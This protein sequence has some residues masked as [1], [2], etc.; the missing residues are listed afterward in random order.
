M[1]DALDGRGRVG[2]VTGAGR[3][4]GRATAERLARD[5]VRVM[6]VSRT[7]QE[8]A[9]LADAADVQWLAADVT[10]D[11]E[12]IVAETRERLGQIEILVNNA[13]AGSAG[14]QPVWA[15]SL[16]R[17]RATLA[18]NLDAPFELTRLALPGMT[19]HGWGRVIM[20]SSLAALAGAVAPGMSAYATSKHGLLGLMRAVAVEVAGHGVTCNAVLPGSVRTR[21]SERK[22]AEE[23]QAAGTTVEAAWEA[24]AARTTGGRLVTAAE[25]ADTIAF[26]CSDA[27]S[28]VNGQTVGV[29]L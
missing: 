17:W 27:G 28:G 13:G 20:V 5:G 18:V 3:G 10:T 15:Q 6:A 26:L 2:L 14:E 24:R 16:E 7:A 21:T 23:A 9:D 4:I 25:V 12:R 19:A 8:L 22:V 1:A 11:A 29:T